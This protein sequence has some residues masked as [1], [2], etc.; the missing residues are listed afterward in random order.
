MK[1]SGSIKK[2][3]HWLFLLSVVAKGLDGLLETVGGVLVLLAS[4]MDLTNLVI[5][6]TAP[7][8]TEDP[9]DLMANYLRHVVYHLSTG[10]KNFATAY[11]LINGIVKMVLVT[12]LLR[13][14]SW[15]YRPAL[16]LLVVFVGYQLCRFTH[17]HS[18]ILLGF[19][20]LDLLAVAF[21]WIEYRGR[22]GSWARNPAIPH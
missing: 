12:G 22:R 8:L 7:E 16:V 14:Q 15:S 5:F 3:M 20:C 1:I 21:I 17:T 4:R 10:T 13:G 18:M 11:L 2:Y 9:T 19:M 6:L